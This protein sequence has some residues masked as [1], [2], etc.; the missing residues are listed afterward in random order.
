MLGDLPFRQLVEGLVGEGHAA[1]GQV[2]QDPGD[3]L[4]GQP[5]LGGDGVLGGGDVVP[6]GK[7]PGTRSAVTGPMTSLRRLLIRQRAHWPGLGWSGSLQTGQSSQ[8]GGGAQ[9]AQ[10][11][12]VRVPAAIG[13]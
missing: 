10:S 12:R 7:Q 2:G 9:S 1:G 5:A 13:A 8:P 3:G 4:F 6:Q 11:G